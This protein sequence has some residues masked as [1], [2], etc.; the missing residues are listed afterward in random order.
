[1]GED[2]VAAELRFMA[3]FI[4]H[5]K[6]SEGLSVANKIISGQY[7]SEDAAHLRNIVAQFNK[8]RLQGLESI[9]KI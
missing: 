7:T 1:V 4:T 5:M 8:T 6:I 9:L 3:N 2:R